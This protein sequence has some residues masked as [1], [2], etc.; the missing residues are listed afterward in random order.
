MSAAH[1]PNPVVARTYDVQVGGGVVRTYANGKVDAVDG[2][3]YSLSPG[4]DSVEELRAWWAE[5]FGPRNNPAEGVRPGTFNC[6]IGSYLPTEVDG[7]SGFGTSKHVWVDATNVEKLSDD[8]LTNALFYAEIGDRDDEKVK[9]LRRES[10]R[11][12]LLEG[13]DAMVRELLTKAAYEAMADLAEN[14]SMHSTGR[15]EVY[16]QF[17]YVATVEFTVG[18]DEPEF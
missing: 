14:S 11:R 2:V 3:G 15:T 5:E 1:A 17:G 18:L 13:D 6:R 8:H 12:S 16:N 10:L 7:G 4:F 9:L